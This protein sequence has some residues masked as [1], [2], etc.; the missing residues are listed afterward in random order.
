MKRSKLWL[1][2]PALLLGLLLGAAFYGA[3][4][5]SAEDEP[6][7]ADTADAVTEAAET[8]E[9]TPPAG[10]EDLSPVPEIMPAAIDCGRD[11]S[12][13][14][15]RFY[16][17]DLY[18]WYHDGIHYALENGLMQGV[19]DDCFDP[20]GACTRAMAVTMLWRLDGCPDA[21]QSAFADVE[22]GSWYE[23]AVNWAYDA[24]LTY[25]MTPDTFVPEAPVTREQLADLL[26]RW[27]NYHGAG[28]EAGSSWYYRLIF[29]D[30]GQ[31]S[32]WAYEPLCWLV[33][34]NVLLGLENGALAP[35][36]L[37]TR[38]QIAAVFQR[39]RLN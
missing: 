2:L 21:P 22:Y 8:P 14:A 3:E 37:A 13:P 5:V 6:A 35:G 16:D 28:F 17:V 19:S 39:I 20:D 31:V 12:C 38:A 29:I 27:L 26:Y 25:G 9:E 1:L 32:E 30:A 4:P 15:A 10:T 7:A 23:A 33:K 24:G 34:N 18:A 36:G 11:A